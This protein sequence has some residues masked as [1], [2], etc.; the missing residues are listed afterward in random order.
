MSKKNRILDNDIANIKDVIYEIVK[1]DL[2]LYGNTDNSK[3]VRVFDTGAS[4]DTDEGKLDFHGFLSHDVLVSYAKYM[5][6][7]RLLPNGELRD[8]DNWKKGIPKKQY[9]KSM[10]RHFMDVWANSDN[11]DAT[12]DEKEVCLNALLFNV[13]GLLHEELKSR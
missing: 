10:F 9:I 8:S 3:S 11:E 12:L 5:H 1:P 4:R 13:M 6:D 7:N 2:N